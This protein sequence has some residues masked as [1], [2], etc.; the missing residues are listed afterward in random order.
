M[1]SPVRTKIIFCLSIDRR[2]R[3]RP[4]RNPRT[5]LLLLL[6]LLLFLLLLF[7]LYLLYRGEGEDVHAK[8]GG[9]F[10]VENTWI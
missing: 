8:S 4:H 1:W 9:M 7:L 6:F 5:Q 2:R 3:P 10:L